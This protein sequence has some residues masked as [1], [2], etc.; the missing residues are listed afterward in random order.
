M[1]EQKSQEIKKKRIVQLIIVLNIS[2]TPVL[3]ISFL[4]FGG[5]R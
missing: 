4:H 2:L 1:E 3:F 5:F